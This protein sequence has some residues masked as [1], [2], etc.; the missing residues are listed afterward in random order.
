M[1]AMVQDLANQMCPDLSTS[2]YLRL[3]IKIDLN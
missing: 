1:K 2:V 3:S